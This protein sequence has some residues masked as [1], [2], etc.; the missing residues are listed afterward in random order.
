MKNRWTVVLIPFVLTACASA[1]GP[2]GPSAGGAPTRAAAPTIAPLP[3]VPAPTPDTALAGWQNLD[4]NRDG[5]PGTSTERALADLLAG[6]TPQPV[7]VAVIDGG[8]DTAHV[9]LRGS[10]WHNPGET[11]GNHRD[12]D[13]NGYV[14]DVFGWNFIG[15]AD[16]RNVNA[17]T[18]EATRLYARCLA[19]APADGYG[20]DEITGVYEELK[21]EAEGLAEQVSQIEAALGV[22]IPSLEQAT[23]TKPL[24]RQA[25]EGFE[26]TDQRLGQMRTVWLQLD[27][28]GITPEIVSET[29]DDVRTR[30]EYSLDREFDPRYIVGDDFANGEERFYGNADVTGPS[31]GH[32]THVAGIIAGARNGLGND[33]I[34]APEVRIMAV[35]AVPDGDERDK[36]VANAIRYAVDQGARVINMSFGKGFS[37]RKSLVDEAVKYADAHGVLLIHAAGN[38][39]HDLEVERNFPNRDYLDGGSA[40]LWVSVGASDWKVDSLATSFSNYGRTKVDLFAPGIDILSAKPGDDFV[41]QQGTSMAAPVVTGVAALLMAY[42]PELTAADVKEI[43]LASAVRYTDRMVPRPGEPSAPGEA[44]PLVRFGDLSAT[45]GVVN[46]YEAVRLAI[47]RG[48]R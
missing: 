1:G 6:R 13:R 36:D 39:G 27:D 17:D 23:G 32:G 41:E 24:T 43:L 31:A 33:G 15:G 42:F 4:L 11:P 26:T 3:L 9:D 48:G 40:S 7:V 46:T 30:L 10:M 35:R 21:S 18:Y 12:D 34:A 5:V 2:P 37:P 20:C 16:G 28:A 14:D 45:G 25:V 22:I 29:G 8:V 19:D 38:D 47:E 44:A